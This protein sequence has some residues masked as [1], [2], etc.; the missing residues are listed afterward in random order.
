[1][2]DAGVASWTSYNG[3]T[4]VKSVATFLNGLQGLEIGSAGPGQGVEQNI[5]TVV[6]SRY[7]AYCYVISTAGA[8]GAFQFEALDGS[9][10]LNL[11]YVTHSAVTWVR[12]SIEFTATS[13]T[14]TIRLQDRR[15]AGGTMVADDMSCRNCDLSSYWESK[16]FDFGSERDV[17]LLRE[18]VPFANEE[19]NYPVQ[20]ILTFDKG[21][22]AT[23]DS[24]NLLSG[25]ALWG[26]FLWGEVVW[27]GHREIQDD[28]YNMDQTDFR[29]VRIK[30]SNL[31]GGQPF[32]I[33]KMYMAVGNLGK[34]W[35]H[36]G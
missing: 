5:T 26:E 32:N 25:A 9:T 14:T 11:D 6:G 13:T 36:N 4:R 20:F 7:R 17:K 27:G 12:A 10:S 18:F 31:V 2:E 23:T 29:T 35:Y 28:L 34:R 30:F 21:L 19:G 24:I 33:N 8:D 15:G 16:D 22:T 3:G 1:M